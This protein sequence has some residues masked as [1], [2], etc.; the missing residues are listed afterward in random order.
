M[1]QKVFHLV[2]FQCF[3]I[4]RRLCGEGGGGGGGGGRGGAVSAAP[5]NSI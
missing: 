3:Q 5:L 2:S 1:L 4:C